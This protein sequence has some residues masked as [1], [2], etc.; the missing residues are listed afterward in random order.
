[1]AGE[2]KFYAVSVV[3]EGCIQY[4]IEAKN[5]E[6]AKEQAKDT[7]SSF[8]EPPAEEHTETGIRCSKFI[9]RKLSAEPLLYSRIA[10]KK[11]TKP[12]K[13]FATAALSI[14][15]ATTST[16]ERWKSSVMPTS[17]I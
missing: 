10:K 3:F 16:L 1:M 7:P 2:L 11:P 12:Q 14:L 9:S 4:T 15:V 8:T 6:D 17:K 5:E 13:N